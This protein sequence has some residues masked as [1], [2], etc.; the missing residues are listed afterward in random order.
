MPFACA[1]TAPTFLAS[2]F[3]LRE[4][5][6]AGTVVGTLNAT[7]V[8]MQR[9]T[10]A[11]VSGNGGTPFALDA[12]SGALTVATPSML[13]FATNPTFTLIVNAL[14]NNDP[15]AVTQGFVTI[16]LLRVPKPPVLV[17]TTGTI[18][19]NATVNSAVSPVLVAY[20]DTGAGTNFAISS[21]SG[22]AFKVIS[23]GSNSAQLLLATAG[24][25][26]YWTTPTMNVALVLTTA[27]NLSLTTVATV[28][29][30]VL[31]APTPPNVA[32]G[33]ELTM[34]ETAAK[35]ASA[36]NPAWTSPVVVSSLNTPPVTFT[37]AALAVYG[38]I[39]TDGTSPLLVGAGNP[40]IV[41]STTGS[42][43]F[44]SPLV[45][46]DASQQRFVGLYLTR[47]AYIVTVQISDNSGLST[48]MNVTVLQLVANSATNVAVFSQISP[49]TGIATSGGDTLTLVGSSFD[50]LAGLPAFVT[51]GPYT[52]RNCVA[53]AAFGVPFSADYT[54]ASVTCLNAPGSGINWIVSLFIN[55][56]K[57]QVASLITLSYAAPTVS[58]ISATFP[59][60]PFAPPSSVIPSQLSTQGG[61]LFYL[62]GT[63]LG[64]VWCSLF[65]F[66]TLHRT[67]P[68]G[69]YLSFQEIEKSNISVSYGPPSNPT[70]F[71]AQVL[72]AS[73]TW[74]YVKSSEGFGVSLSVSVTVSGQTAVSTST[75][76]AYGVRSNLP[77]LS[78]YMP[79]LKCVSILQIPRITGI[80]GLSSVDLPGAMPSDGGTKFI[81][82]GFNFGPASLSG[83]DVTQAVSFSYGYSQ[84]DATSLVYVASGC[85][86]GSNPHTAITCTAVGGIGSSLVGAIV[87]SGIAGTVDMSN[88]TA[89]AYA[90]PT[91]TR[92]S[93]AGASNAN[94]A[95]GGLITVEGSGFGP[96]LLNG[97]SSLDAGS[98]GWQRGP[99]GLSYGRYAAS[100]CAVLSSSI[101]TCSSVPGTGAGYAWMLTIAGQ[102]V[103]ACC[104]EYLFAMISCRFMMLTV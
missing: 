29:V 40:V 13:V 21:S 9:V 58:G 75:G 98:P 33:Q 53:N 6:P 81:L 97:A 67:S 3:S 34:Q 78:F 71:F 46:T 24:S 14:T 74:L 15:L 44:I 2:N 79:H 99:G 26:N 93:G 42:V 65:A 66:V 4:G 59:N 23:V 91:V 88:S 19:V 36:S 39:M 90:P 89:L 96:A 85:A 63:S 10:Y 47:A 17:T 43:G 72:N 60:D 100:G 5:S 7:T 31:Y 55:N 8:A 12:C 54:P 68:H 16:S 56:V 77:R 95:G 1:L 20:D 18:Y 45:V 38:G 41:N 11:I 27:N 51:Y 80:T 61:E 73:D 28:T 82:S 25:L 22:N 102:Q 94:T 35:N 84:S 76:L 83:V 70:A 48:T 64:Q 49:T 57:V 52:A 87:I 69:P 103:N 101:L 104:R 37:Y 62:T 32:S 86:K 30:T 50:G 92:I